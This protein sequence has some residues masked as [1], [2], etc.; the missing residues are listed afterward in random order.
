MIEAQTEQQGA[1]PDVDA[2]AIDER[3]L[4]LLKKCLTRYLFIDEEVREL[5]GWGWK[6]T[7]YSPVDRLLSKGG[8]RVS[9]VGGSAAARE[10]GRD[11][12][13]HAETMIGLRRLDNIQMCVTDAVRRGVPG[14]LIEAGVWRGG[15]TIFMRATLAALGDT[16]RRVWVADSFQGLPRPK[17][18][19]YPADAQFDR[20]LRLMSKIGLGAL[21]SE[22]VVQMSEAL[23]NRL[24][25]RVLAVT[26]DDVKS[27]FARY[28]LLDHRVEFLVGWFA[29]TLPVAPIEKLAVMRLDGDLYESTMDALS[30]LYPKLS[31]GG[32]VI[33]DDYGC[34]D[35]CRQAVT[36]Y[37]EAQ[38]I[39]DEIKPIDWTGVYWQRT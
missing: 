28:G 36:D 37:R 24:H 13:T 39:N 4:D 33:V 22:W 17:P 14:D 12:P 16:T 19:R 11:R 32:Y 15:A 2:T 30:S 35:A 18:D 20:R 34:I 21:N 8:L 25:D 6:R 10:V 1:A 29:D 26:V 23:W 9:R 31:V 5:I 3:Y 7:L 27:N 38:A